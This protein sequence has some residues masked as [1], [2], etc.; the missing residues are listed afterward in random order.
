MNIFN[1]CIVIYVQSLTHIKRVHLGIESLI[2]TCMFNL[3]HP[4]T[5][6]I[7]ATK[8]HKYTAVHLS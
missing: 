5:M 4:L 6:H 3:Q 1:I 2:N 7:T 8:C